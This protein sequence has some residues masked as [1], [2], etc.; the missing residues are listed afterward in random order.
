MTAAAFHAAGRPGTRNHGC[1]DRL[2]CTQCRCQQR[3]RGAKDRGIVSYQVRQESRVCHDATQAR[4]A[5]CL[6]DAPTLTSTT[7]YTIAWKR[8]TSDIALENAVEFKALPSGL[9]AVPTDLVYFTHEGYAGLSAFAKGAASAEERNANFVSVGILVNKEG[10]FGR[11]GRGWLLAGRLEKL[12]AALADDSDTVTPLDE[13][14]EEHHAKSISGSDGADEGHAKG[15]K[16]H[17]RA[18]AIS[19]VSAAPRDDESLP[20]YHPALS[21]LRYLDTFG[22]L[23]FRLQQAALLRK[24]I[25]FVASPPVRIACEYGMLTRSCIRQLES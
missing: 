14:W 16:G 8:S 10:R 6:N 15:A 12:A 4:P 19:T 24:R 1:L 13:F 11:L 2:E 23:V 22:P 17:S 9:H 20:E 25:L 18:R 7:S 5:Y 3:E 21:I